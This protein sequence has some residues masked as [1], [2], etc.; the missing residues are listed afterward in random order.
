MASVN[1]NFRDMVLKHEMIA[2]FEKVKHTPEMLKQCWEEQV[3]SFAALA[4][5]GW[6]HFAI[7]DF[8]NYVRTTV[9]ET[10]LFPGSS[11]GTL[12]ISKPNDGFLNYQQTL[13]ISFDNTTGLFTMKY[14]DWD[15][16]DSKDDFEKAILWTVKCSGI[17]LGQK[18]QDFLD[19]QK[20]WR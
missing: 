1:T 10:T 11:L 12:L 3:A 15:T 18:F 8:I 9:Y 20:N 13:S 4:N 19:W 7:V 6:V 16:I 5:I 17:E 14:S 2:D